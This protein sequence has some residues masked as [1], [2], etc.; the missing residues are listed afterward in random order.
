[1]ADADSV[2]GPLVW[3]D[4]VL[5]WMGEIAWPGTDRVEVLLDD[6]AREAALPVARQSL[7]WVRAHEPE[8]RRAV[9]AEFLAWCNDTFAPA[10][11]ISEEEFMRTVVLH[12]LWLE[13]DG[14]LRVVYFDMQLFGGHVFY[15]EFA[16]DKSLEGFSVD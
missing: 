11:P 5:R 4:G 8:V 13:G 14:S 9:A 3:H 7:E 16:A 2:F 6:P 1:M 10:Q 12:Q 15:A